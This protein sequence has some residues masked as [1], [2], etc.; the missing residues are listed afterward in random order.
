[1]MS[2]SKTDQR[3][4]NQQVRILKLLFKFRF[5]TT[6]TL[7]DIMKV[8]RP[9]AYEALE[10]LVQK[11]LLTKVYKPEYRIDR[12]PA[13]YYLNKAGVTTVR[14]VLDVKESVVHA[15][16]KNDEMTDEFIQHSIKLAQCYSAITR[17]LPESTDIFS[18]TEINRFGQ[19]P[20]NR[21]DM[22]IRTPDGREVIVVIADDKPLYIVRKRLEEILTHSEDEGW[23]GDYPTVC[24]VL[25]DNSAKNSFLYTT[26][27]KLDAMG[28]DVDNFNVLAT[29]L[30]SFSADDSQIWSSVYSPKQP[31]Y[32]FR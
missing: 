11:E 26:F 24:F 19:F 21:P 5:L 10:Q 1:M 9:S 3:L 7:S 15:L 20:K 25:K 30:T 16:Y 12:R 4:T 18:K 17:F 31:Q 23:E 32:L 27:K 22:Y 2:D 29:T 28:M 14:K 13:Y 6:P 8:Q